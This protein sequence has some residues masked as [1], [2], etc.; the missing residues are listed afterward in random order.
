MMRNEGAEIAAGPA[1]LL[2][3]S[4]IECVEQ[5]YLQYGLGMARLFEAGDVAGAH[6]H[7]IHA[8]K[9]AARFAHQELLTLARIGE[10]R[11]LI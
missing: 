5:G 2:E 3:D 11:M 8:G 4:G 9:I 6:T 1:R 10:G 7:F